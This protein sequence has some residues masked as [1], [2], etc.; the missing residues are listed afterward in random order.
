MF[1]FATP[2]SGIVISAREASH[3]FALYLEQASQGKTFTVLKHGKPMAKLVPI[4]PE[5]QVLR[6]LKEQAAFD[7]KIAKA[8]SFRFS[9]PYAGKFNRQDAYEDI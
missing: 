8:L 6:T 5:G 1:D 4:R 9:K 3:H 7:K 2:A